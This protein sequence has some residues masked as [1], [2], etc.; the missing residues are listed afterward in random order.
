MFSERGIWAQIRVVMQSMKY[1]HGSNFHRLSSFSHHQQSKPPFPSISIEAFKPSP[2]NTS[3]A[4]VGIDRSHSQDIHDTRVVARS[5][6]IPGILDI[7]GPR[8]SCDIAVSIFYPLKFSFFIDWTDGSSRSIIIGPSLPLRH[9]VC[10]LLV[11]NTLF[12]T[13]LL[14]RCTL[15]KEGMKQIS[16][17]GRHHH[18]G[19]DSLFLWPLPSEFL[20]LFCPLPKY[21]ALSITYAL[22]YSQCTCSMLTLTYRQKLSLRWRQLA[23]NLRYYRPDVWNTLKGTRS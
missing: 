13:L 11:F 15:Y 22:A 14:V 4:T 21:S 19:K 20:R 9:F 3:P 10:R 1:S 6:I 23:R 2:W 7:R 5:P 17:N 16:S 8:P 12:L 18:A